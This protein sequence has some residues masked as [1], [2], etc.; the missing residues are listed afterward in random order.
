MSNT[1]PNELIQRVGQVTRLLRDSM[2]ELGLDK[3]VERAALAIPDTRDRLGYIANMT[4]QAA[5]RSLNAVERAQPQQEALGN[6][7]EALE[8]RWQAWEASAQPLDSA[9]ELVADTRRFLA[10]EAPAHVQATQAELLEILMAQDFQDLTG[11][12]I[13]KMMVLIR[14]IEHQ[15]IQVLLSGRPDVSE[16][17][18]REQLAAAEAERERHSEP[19]LLNG[20]QIKPVAGEA[21]SSQDQVDD[22][23]AELGF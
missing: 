1:A 15:L 21:V 12:V 23:L 14:E 10:E 3:E 9:S 20:P 11:Q 8:Q 2:R 18:L 7:A 6:G 19:Q 17:V 13:K 16:R 4:E 5:N 22:L